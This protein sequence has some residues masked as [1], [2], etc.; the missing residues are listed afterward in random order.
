ML[1][2]ENGLRVSK[3]SVPLH[4]KQETT[5][6]NHWHKPPNTMNNP[7]VQRLLVAALQVA[8]T[9]IPEIITYIKNKK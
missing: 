8:A 3:T 4:R 9:A 2:V 6:A 1:C 7:I 5:P